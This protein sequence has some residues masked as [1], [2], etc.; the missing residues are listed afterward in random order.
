MNERER[1]WAI[2]MAAAEAGDT[3]AYRR[4]LAELA[5]FL[6]KVVRRRAG[7]FGVDDAEVEDVVQEAL[8]AI[9]LKRGTWDPA[10]P[11]GPWVATIARNKLTDALRRRGRRITV[12]IGDVEE[13]LA[14]PQEEDGLSAH[15]TDRLLSVLK[16]RQH[17][18]VRSISLEGADI[19]A[20]AAKFG[21]SEGAVRVALHRGLS[22][23]SAAYRSFRE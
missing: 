10:Q 21:M 22:A 6:R 12:P 19:R 20:T 7:G 8:L 16:G 23:L 14:A 15:E 18:V 2:W 5:V 11:V 3:S 17:D 9:H 1:D 4:L 13:F